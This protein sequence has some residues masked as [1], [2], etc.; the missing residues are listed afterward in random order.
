MEI[1]SGAHRKGVWFDMLSV[2]MNGMSIL[3]IVFFILRMRKLKKQLNLTSAALEFASTKPTHNLHDTTKILSD[4][5]E[6]ITAPLQGAI[7]LATTLLEGGLGKLNDKQFYQIHLIVSEMR[8]TNQKVNTLIEMNQGRLQSNHQRLMIHS[9]IELSLFTHHALAYRHRIRFV[10]DIQNVLPEV[11]GDES[12]IQLVFHQIAGTLIQNHVNGQL[13]VSSC[14]NEQKLEITIQMFEAQLLHAKSIAESLQLLLD[15]KELSIQFEIVHP[16]HG[17][18]ITLPISQTTNS[19]GKKNDTVDVDHPFEKMHNSLLQLP[20]EFFANETSTQTNL[21]VW[22][23]DDELINLLVL[24]AYLLQEQY[25]VSKFAS[26]VDALAEL[27]SGLKPDLIITDLMMPS[28]NGL[29]LCEQI[30]TRYTSIELP[31]IIVTSRTLA[32]DPDQKEEFGANDYLTRPFT[33]I[34]LISRV[35]TQLRISQWNQSLEKQLIERTKSVR[36]LMNQAGHGFLLI[37]Q[38]LRIQPDFS[39]LCTSLFQ[40]E[41]ENYYLPDLLYPNPSDHKNL[42]E[43]TLQ[44]LFETTQI[45]IITNMIKLLPTQLIV[46]RN[47]LSFMY[48]LIPGLGRMETLL[49]IRMSDMTNLIQLEQRVNYAES[50]LQALMLCMK[51]PVQFRLIWKSLREYASHGWIE[52]VNQPIPVDQL[53]QNVVTPLQDFIKSLRSFCLQDTVNKLHQYT[54][55]VNESR[56]E[57]K[58][59]QQLLAWFRFH[60]IADCFAKDEQF[61]LNCLGDT[62]FEHADEIKVDRTKLLALETELRTVLTDNQSDSLVKSLHRIYYQPLHGQLLQLSKLFEKRAYS[63]NKRV[64]PIIFHG[65][66]VCIDQN[67]TNYINQI[68]HDWLT[69]IIDV[70]IETIEERLDNMKP[71]HAMIICSVKT[72][73]EQIEISITDDGRGWKVANARKIM[74]KESVESITSILNLSPEEITFRIM[75]KYPNFNAIHTLLEQIGGSLRIETHWNE[76]SVFTIKIPCPWIAELESM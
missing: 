21:Q 18:K 63:Q 14:I 10:N 5:H 53:I 32:F 56:H 68:I 13:V 22:I 72:S 64:L 37:D 49:M 20:E 39:D 45:D 35:H 55:H 50:Q 31:I 29:E 36:Q 58:S 69:L 65:T 1:I 27:S 12:F 16:H 74:I 34:E 46:N 54:M 66:S 9:I 8:T 76:R 71:E 51:D 38:Q 61:L 44:K 48:Q 3:L 60:P 62:F 41:L 11:F 52:L 30:R 43:S 6:Q 75:Q 59:T 28:M 47:N 15:T 7:N 73:D 26:A 67:M 17:V 25:I 24:E 57:L 40:V 42:L 70:S 33:R 19:M 2:I 4:I 23:I